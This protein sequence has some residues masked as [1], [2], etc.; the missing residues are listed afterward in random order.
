MLKNQSCRVLNFVFRKPKKK[1][2]KKKILKTIF[3]F[4]LILLYI[5]LL[6]LLPSIVICISVH[7][8]GFI[9]TKFAAQ[10]KSLHNN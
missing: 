5:I 9:K 10:Q 2:K 4:I 7:W 1:P 6:L 8:L 3:S